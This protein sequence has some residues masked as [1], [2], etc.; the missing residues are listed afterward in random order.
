MT[1]HFYIKNGKNFTRTV[2]IIHMSAR[3]VRQLKR[4]APSV[5]FSDESKFVF[6]VN[7]VGRETSGVLPDGAV[8]PHQ[9]VLSMRM[10]IRETIKSIFAQQARMAAS[11]A[12][13]KNYSK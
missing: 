4:G 5:N 6:R 3:G 9:L 13:L 7:V 10:V 12:V 2:I 8:S 11:I 1:I